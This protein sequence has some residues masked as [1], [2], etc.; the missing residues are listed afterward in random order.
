MPAD[1]LAYVFVTCLVMVALAESFAPGPRFTGE[2]RPGRVHDGD[3]FA[4]VCGAQVS[5]A[6]LTGIDTPELTDARCPAERRAAEAARGALAGMIAAAGVVE[7]ARHGTDRY[8]RD[9]VALRLDGEDAAR[10]L[11]AAGH[12]RRYDG[13][14][15]RGWCR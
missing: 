6:R 3:T 1:L 15:R 10:A 4:L 8:G 11:I 5:T 9:L 13:G 12:G 14:A 7:I 2:C